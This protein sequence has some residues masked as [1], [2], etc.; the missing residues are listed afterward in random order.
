[1]T[2][3]CSAS[4]SSDPALAKGSVTSFNDVT[5]DSET[6]LLAAVTAGPV[7]V[8]IEADQSGFQ[9]YKSGVFSGTCGTNLDHGVLVVGY[10]TDSGKDYWKVKNSW[11]TTWGDQGYIRLVR[12]SKSE[13][14]RKLLG[15]GG[16][17]GSSGECGLLKQPSYPVV[18]KTVHEE[19]GKVIRVPISKRP[20]EEIVRERLFSPKP[21]NYGVAEVTAEGKVVINDYQNAQ[22]YGQATVGTPPQTFNVIFDTGSANLWVPN[23]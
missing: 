19:T 17:G 21:E 18:S 1:M 2:G 4:K 7:S 5:S 10:G 15:G 6:Q 3:S 11:G 12:S 9:F 20:T 22:Y 13:T 23:S 8:A 16:G 14:G